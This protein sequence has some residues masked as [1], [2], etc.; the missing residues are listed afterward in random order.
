M[1]MSHDWKNTAEELTGLMQDFGKSHPDVAK[2]FSQLARAADKDGAMS[3]KD[4]EL[5]ALAI[6]VA[7]R[8][9]GCIA[10]HAKAAA[11]Y[12]ATREEVVETIGVCLYMGGGPSFVYGAPALE[13]FDSFATDA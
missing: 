7:I 4:K 5:M 6:G 11:E 9:E 2:A 8:C 13:A 10:F 1:M 12:G 3:T